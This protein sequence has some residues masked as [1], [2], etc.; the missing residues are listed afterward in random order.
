MNPI[1]YSVSAALVAFV[2]ASGP[3][4]PHARG[5]V[6]TR[7]DFESTAAA[8]GV[9]T[10]ADA[11]TGFAFSLS[12][13]LTLSSGGLVGDKLQGVIATGSNKSGYMGGN[14]TDLTFTGTGDR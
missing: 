8:P 5:E 9:L 10:D 2:L 7:I 4:V 13:N 3:L 1:Q 14:G 6:L 11:F 12:S